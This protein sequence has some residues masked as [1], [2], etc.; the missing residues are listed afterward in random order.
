MGA[1]LL[2]MLFI[3]QGTSADHITN[4]ALCFL[5]NGTGVGYLQ[6]NNNTPYNI[7]VEIRGKNGSA[8]PFTIKST[9]SFIRIDMRNGTYRVIVYVL[10]PIGQI[11]V[12]Y[13]SYNVNVPTE[14]ETV[15]LTVTT[16][17]GYIPI[18]K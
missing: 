12:L 6:I 4:C 11:P 3:F 7:I 15:S 1:C 18:P 9:P 2:G 16:P 17:I 10:T 8:G 5:E 14:F 13:K